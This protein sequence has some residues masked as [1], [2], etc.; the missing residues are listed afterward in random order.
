MAIFGL[1]VIVMAFYGAKHGSITTPEKIVEN[2]G[3]DDSEGFENY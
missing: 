2:S 1:V 3:Y